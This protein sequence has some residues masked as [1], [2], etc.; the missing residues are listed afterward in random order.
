LVR[1]ARGAARATRRPTPKAIH[2]KRPL[3]ARAHT[4]PPLLN[5]CLVTTYAIAA[6]FAD[7]FSHPI[8]HL[9]AKAVALLLG[10]RSYARHH[11]HM[12][13]I[14]LIC[15]PSRSYARHHAHMRHHAH[16]R[17]ITLICAP[18]RSHACGPLR[19]SCAPS[20]VR[21]SRSMTTSTATSTTTS[22][23]GPCVLRAQTTGTDHRHASR[24]SVHVCCMLLEGAW[25]TEAGSAWGMMPGA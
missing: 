13:A 12:H 7:A 16:I 1:S 20:R 22:T 6:R 25:P 18:S 24:G 8:A 3:Q 4:Q 14:T 9:P 15:T 11:A 21:I 19:L 5:P 10:R 17:A 23:A 2:Q